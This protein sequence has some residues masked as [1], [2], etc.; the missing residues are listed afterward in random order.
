MSCIEANK[1]NYV[2]MIK[3]LKNDDFTHDADAVGGV[4]PGALHFLDRDLFAVT[5]IACRAGQMKRDYA[6]QIS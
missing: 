1:A 3:M 6:Q 5:A 4:V 2:G